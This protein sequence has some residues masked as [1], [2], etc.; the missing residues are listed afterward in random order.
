MI[1]KKR[2]VATCF[3][4]CVLTAALP[5]CT[6]ISNTDVSQTPVEITPSSTEMS[7]ISADMQTEAVLNETTLDEKSNI[8]TETNPEIDVPFAKESDSATENSETEDVPIGDTGMTASEWC[9]QAQ[10]IYTAAASTYFIYLCSSDGFAYD[11]DDVT[12]DGWVRVTNYQTIEEAEAEYYDIFARAG[13]EM[14]LNGQFRMEN[15]KLYRLC[16]DRGGDISYVS[17]EVTELTGSTADTLTF[18]V[19]STY[20]EPDSTEQTTREDTF[21]L[22]LEHGEW[23]VGQF[24]MPY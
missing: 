9:T 6:D 19:V 3:I 18:S 4:M 15:D 8:V 5:G 13:H 21:T 17:S 14:D 24:T 12:E 11:T 7:E 23:H 16:G 2:M 20:Q 22:I 1:P 10:K